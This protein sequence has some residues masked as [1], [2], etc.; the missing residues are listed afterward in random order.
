MK[1]YFLSLVTILLTITSAQAQGDYFAPIGAEWYY[2]SINQFNYPHYSV[3]RVE[4]DTVVSGVAC[5]KITGVYV[6]RDSA[7]RALDDIYVY[8]TKD[9]VF[10]Y[11]KTFSRFTPLYIFN[12]E[13]GDTMIYDCPYYD[14]APHFTFKY[15]TPPIDSFFESKVDRI[16]ILNIND[17]SL[18]QVYPSRIPHVNYSWF[19]SGV[20]TERIGSSYFMIPHSSPGIPEDS[21]IELRCYTDHEI[22]YQLITPCDTLFQRPTS[23]KHPDNFTNS[24]IVVYPNPST[25]NFTINTRLDYPDQGQINITDLSGRVIHQLLIPKEKQEMYEF[26][27]QLP[28]GIYILRYTVNNMAYAAKLMIQ[29]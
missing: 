9:T 7:S 27:M 26:S 6:P 23:V 2:G 21:E 3:F 8:S 17:L 22:T 18:K 15:E 19:F 14:Y 5:R 28:A 25:G 11:N 13:E 12:V 16:E 10:Y 4:K 29:P 1:N 20:Y 24:N